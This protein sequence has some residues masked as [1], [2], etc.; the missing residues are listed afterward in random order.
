MHTFSK[1]HERILPHSSDEA[2]VSQQH[3]TPVAGVSVVVT[4]RVIQQR[5]RQR[6][7][8]AATMGTRRS[9]EGQHFDSDVTDSGSDGI[10]PRW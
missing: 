4:G 5:I 8:P 1:L 2:S 10:R 9:D 7:L 3:S 6:G